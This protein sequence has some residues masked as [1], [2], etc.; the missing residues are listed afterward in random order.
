[1]KPEQVKFYSLEVDD[2]SISPV[3]LLAAY[4]GLSKAQIKQA[5]D[6]GAVWIQRRARTQQ[7]I[8]TKDAESLVATKQAKTI[9]N[10]VV[11]LRRAKSALSV[12]D[13][14]SFYYNLEVLASRC[15]LPR[16][17]E[18]L[19]AYSI[20]DKPA[21]V[22]C[23]G[24][25][26][27]D[28]TTLARLVVKNHFSE[29]ECIIV[30]RLDRMAS[31]LII[32]AH[33]KKTAAAF[34][35][36]FAQRKLSKTYSAIV[37]GALPEP[38]P[39]K[40]DQTIEGQSAVTIIHESK[41][42]KQLLNKLKNADA[43]ESLDNCTE[44]LLTIESGRKHQIRRHLAGIDLPIVGDRLYGA[45]VGTNQKTALLDLQLRSVKLSFKDPMD[46]F[47]REWQL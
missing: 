32:L 25:K 5:M 40:I 33:N 41:P 46:G 42:A 26:W 4:T 39:Y 16:L 27:G 45:A 19:E 6:K 38:L 23:Q 28:H 1:M 43:G 12:G 37:K 36:M 21:G 10:K 9:T 20:W 35:H 31:G 17:I 13:R 14:L 8:K 11:R 29:R 24:S 44:L 2:S 22:L 18:D 47:F 30:H 15:E 3:A 7:A 34:T